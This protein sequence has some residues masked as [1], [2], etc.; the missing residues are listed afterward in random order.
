MDTPLLTLQATRNLMLA[1]QG[2]LT[3]PAQTTVKADLLP[4]IRRIHALQI[5]TIHVVARAPYHVIWSRL[6]QYDPTWLEEHHAEGALFEYWAHAACFIPIEDYPL[7][8]RIM[9]DEIGGWDNYRNWAKENPRLVQGVK[10]YI[11][12]NGAV[13]S[14]DFKRPNKGGTWWDWKAEKVALEYLFSQGD[15]MIARREGFQRVYDLRERVLP[16]WD[17]NQ[18]PSY[19]EVFRRQVLNAIKALG[20]AREDWVAP[21]FYL[22]KLKVANLLPILIEED[23]L[24][25]VSV[26]GMT[27]R[28]VYVHQ[29]HADL[30]EAA[31]SGTLEARL[32]TLL[33][34]F[35][36]LITDRSRTRALFDF[37]YT[38]ECYTPAPKREYGYFTL[39][40]L[41]RG[42][43]VGRL[44]A[45]AWR[46]E[47]E[48]E[49][50]KLFLEPEVPAHSLLISDLKQTLRDYAA[51][52]GLEHVVVRWSQPSNLA[53]VLA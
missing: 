4:V 37:D 11:Q 46:K 15:L 38:L 45:K 1:A 14:A 51:W 40:I 17:D 10:A 18:V 5:D 12:E 25:K 48:L 33:S 6:G 36:P 29:D 32:T 44:D 52:Q 26:E 50:I 49:V 43:L 31:L 21:Y 23:L 8:R 39:P 42:K 7:Y 47:R 34:P 3:P 22:P 30:L 16:G 13:K 53:E 35:D 28:P 27:D 41:S 19:E 9:L 24:S 20:A 2:L